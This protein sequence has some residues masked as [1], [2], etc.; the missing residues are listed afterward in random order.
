MNQKPFISVCVR[1][2]KRPDGLRK[3]LQGL[4]AQKHLETPFEIIIVDND[5][6]GSGREIVEQEQKNMPGI[7]ITYD[8]EPAKNMAKV[9]NRVTKSAKGKWIACI[10]DDEIPDP[11]WLIHYHTTLKKYDADGVFGP[12]IPLLP[13]KTA[14]W[15]Y[16]GG[17]FNRSRHKTGTPVPRGEVRIG[18]VFFKASLI[19]DK[20]EPFDTSFGMATEGDSRFFTGLLNEGARFVWC[21]E[22]IVH[23]TVPPSRT[24]LR[25]LLQRYFRGGQ[26]YTLDQKY[27]HGTIKGLYL[28]FYGMG[29]F[30]LS[31][32]LAAL[33]L[34]F[35][36]HKSALW[37]FKGAGGL[38]KAL[39]LV[40]RYEE[41]R[42]NS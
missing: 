36:A 27:F 33:A 20:E 9:A 8:I 28:T 41:Y 7:P 15:I 10:D 26:N 3:L 38:G 25:W 23:E 19:M 4:A 34:P 1:T 29:Q 2:Y 31:L 42:R 30:V 5:A 6:S 32:L 21:D 24:T 18:N 39:A 12:V 13:E 16:S 17:F 14:G 40:Y 22:A 35:G 37:L 11:E